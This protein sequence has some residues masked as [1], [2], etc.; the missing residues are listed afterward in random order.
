M[1]SSTPSSSYGPVGRL[2]RWTA[3]HLKLV[4]L[5]WAAIAL[6]LGFFA[7]KVEQD[8]LA[9]RA[10][11]TPRSSRPSVVAWKTGSVADGLH[12]LPVAPWR[13]WLPT[14]LGRLLPNVRFGHAKST[15]P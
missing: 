11:P 4:A 3:T 15:T 5:V 10:S 2:G 12:G 1:S 6:G 9:G 13:R 14:P 7:P 8:G